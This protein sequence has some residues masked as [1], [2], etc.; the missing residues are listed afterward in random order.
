MKKTKGVSYM[1]IKKLKEKKASL[2]SKMEALVNGAEDSL[3]AEEQ[4]SFDSLKVELEDATASIEKAEQFEKI[5]QDAQAQ[6]KRPAPVRDRIVKDSLSD[7][8][9]RTS[10]V[11]PSGVRKVQGLKSFSGPDAS[12]KAFAF[13]MFIRSCNGD[14]QASQWCTEHGIDTGKFAVH[15]STTNSAGGYLVPTQFSDDM[16]R[17]IYSYGVARKNC[18][19]QNLSTDTFNRPKRLT[20]LQAY[21]TA[22]SAAITESTKSYGNIQLVVKDWSILT[23]MTRQLSQDS[24]INV[25]DDLMSEIAYQF[26]YAEDNCLFNGT[27]AA[28][29]A[30]I[31]GLQKKITDIAADPSENPTAPLVEASL[32]GF[33]MD[34]VI[35][36]MGKISGFSLPGS[37]WFLNSTTYYTT[38]LQAAYA[39]T[40]T[41][42]A[43]VISG[44]GED[45]FMGKPVV[46]CDA[47][48]SNIIY[49]GNLEQAVD[50]GDR[51]QYAVDFS[52]SA[53]VGGENVFER[54]QIAVRGFE[55][56]DIN[57]HSYGQGSEPAPI[58]LMVIS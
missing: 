58:A 39:T 51:G 55:R 13:G 5:K 28:G 46:Y 15:N 19:N 2:L 43:N 45:R 38:L 26:A 33:A 21:P 4:A 25:A 37:K 32:S 44:V 56:F 36:L 3:T 6:A 7:V 30:T 18:K 22:E 29:Y 24:L 35:S 34:D 48:P 50:F 49:F 54:N 20:G 47:I 10:I 9:D 1:D 12:E 40:G 11:L 42:V 41:G 52:D 23:R 16:A 31:T 17:L 27:G 14:Y 57:V 8:T 53:T